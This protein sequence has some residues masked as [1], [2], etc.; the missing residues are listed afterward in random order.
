MDSLNSGVDVDLSN[1]LAR[2]RTPH[3]VL[4]AVGGWSAGSPTAFMETYDFRADRWFLSNHPDNSPRAYHGL[5]PLHGKL[6]VIGGFDGNDHFSTVRRY[7]P[8][9]KIWEERACMQYARCYVSCCEL[10]KR[11]N[12]C[13]VP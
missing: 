4:F 6:Y 3:D 7:D 5:V 1:P 12:F 13:L 2:P 8:V 11:L 10:G 9:L